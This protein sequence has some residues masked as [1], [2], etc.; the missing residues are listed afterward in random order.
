LRAGDVHAE[1]QAHTPGAQGI[2]D[3]GKVF[4]VAGVEQLRS[5]V[6]IIDIDAVDSRRGQQAS[7]FGHRRKVVADAATFKKDAAPGVAALDGAIGIVPLIDPA[8]GH[9]RAFGNRSLGCPAGCCEF[10]KQ[11][12]GAIKNAAF[13]AA[14]YQHNSFAF[15]IALGDPKSLRQKRRGKLHRGEGRSRFIHRAHHNCCFRALPVNQGRQAVEILDSLPQLFD[16]GFFKRLVTQRSHTHG[17]RRK[18]VKMAGTQPSLI[19]CLR[20][21]SQAPRQN[22][23]GC[24][25]SE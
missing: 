3:A 11:C 24:K 19:R 8:D 23:S 20:L 9:C 10:S 5:G 16:G 1:S 17:N 7:V 6:H 25:A 22:E 12:K 18:A 15:R 4:E 21:E 2:G 13:A 14:D